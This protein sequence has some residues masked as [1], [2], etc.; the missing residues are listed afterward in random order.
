MGNYSIFKLPFHFAIMQDD[1]NNLLLN[2][3]PFLDIL[4]AMYF[5]NNPLNSMNI[6]SNVFL[7]TWYDL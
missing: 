5:P 7:S 6:E 2:S 1:P 3:H 4:R